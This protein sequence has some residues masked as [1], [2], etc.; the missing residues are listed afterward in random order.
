MLFLLLGCGPDVVLHRAPA[1]PSET[2]PI[3]VVAPETLAFESLEMGAEAELPLTLTSAGAS[4]LTV[5]D[6]A[7]TGSSAFSLVD[8]PETV[9]LARSE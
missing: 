7:L 4:T 5:S 8:P 1:D 9:E 3:L 6:L 2:A